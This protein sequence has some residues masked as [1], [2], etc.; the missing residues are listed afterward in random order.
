M[1]GTHVQCDQCGQTITSGLCDACAAEVTEELGDTRAEL[2]ESRQHSLAALTNG[3]RAI[4]EA[5]RLLVMVEGLEARVAE[6]EREK[7]RW[8]EA[9]EKAFGPAHESLT[10]SLITALDSTEK[11]LKGANAT[12]TTLRTALESCHCQHCG[13]TRWEIEPS[14][15]QRGTACAYCGET[16][17]L[18][19]VAY[20]ALETLKKGEGGQGDRGSV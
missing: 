20:D 9:A 13:G 7:A 12:V 16:A 3:N 14:N 15:G 18:H 10:L 8:K 5:K 19:P 11:L 17:G 2:A 6:L 1:N 4:E